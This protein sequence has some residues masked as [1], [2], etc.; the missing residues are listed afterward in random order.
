M[1][2][3]QDASLTRA[4]FV[5]GVAGRLVLLPSPFPELLVVSVLLTDLPAFRQTYG[6]A[7]SHQLLND[8]TRNIRRLSPDAVLGYIGDG[9]LVLTYEFDPDWTQIA[10][11]ISDLRAVITAPNDIRRLSLVAPPRMGAT[12]YRTQAVSGYG[13]SASSLDLAEELLRQA[14][15]AAQLVPIQ[16]NESFLLYSPVHDDRI[17]NATILDQ[18][19]RRAVVRDEFRLHYQPLVRLDTME[20]IGLEAL[21]R[22]EDPFF[23]LR[24]PDEFIPAAEASGLIVQ[25]GAAVIVA[26]MRQ[27]A[28]WKGAGWIAPR[29]AVNV[30]ASQF[31]DPDFLDIVTGAVSQAGLT[32][33][34]IELE[35]TERTIVSGSEIAVALMRRLRE[36]GFGIAL[37]DFGTGYSSLQYLREL[38]LSKLKIDKA[39]VKHISEQKDA[40]LVRA[41]VG[42]G[43]ALALTVVAEGVETEAQAAQLLSCGCTIGQG[44]LFSRPLPPALIPALSSRFGASRELY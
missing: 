20:L 8:I 42:I 16:G 15:L 34:S 7:V 24:S 1:G 3:V 35:V 26:A 43:E 44:Y 21:I 33:D 27:A 4:H 30:S 23:G 25:I 29:I 11:V 10:D 36:L 37:D 38:P 39:F 12:H 13:P 14:M 17:R 18:S 2:V 9:H 22:W 31:F 5:A 6:E 40:A 28:E 32:P 19:L 41:I